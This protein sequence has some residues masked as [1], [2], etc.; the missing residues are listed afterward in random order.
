MT[1]LRELLL[2]P[3]AH[4]LLRGTLAPGVANSPFPSEDDGLFSRWLS[5]MCHLVKHLD[6][7]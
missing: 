3:F 2:L 6:R 7:C 4:G 5:Q 1:S